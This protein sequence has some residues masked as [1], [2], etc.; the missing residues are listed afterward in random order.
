MT[1]V[2]E[3]CAVNSTDP[4]RVLQVSQLLQE[5]NNGHDFICRDDMMKGV[6]DLYV[7]QVSINT[8]QHSPLYIPYWS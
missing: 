7:I 3:I 4:V 6:Y 2:E 1:L 5:V 8:C